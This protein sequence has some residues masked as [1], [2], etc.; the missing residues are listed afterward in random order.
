M[1]E[2]DCEAVLLLEADKD[3]EILGV[4]LLVSDI[5]E[6]GVRE[7]VLVLLIESVIEAV[8][9]GVSD[10]SALLDLVLLSVIDAV[11][12]GENEIDAVLDGV[13]PRLLGVIDGVNDL[14]GLLVE[15]TV[16]PSVGL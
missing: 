15:D 8:T 6:V 11:F 9:D 2:D 13:I 12:D 7:A 10:G 1:T 16:N 14:E 4:L 5:E 3:I